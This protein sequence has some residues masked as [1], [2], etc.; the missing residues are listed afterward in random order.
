MVSVV[1]G[2]HDNLRN[3][4][5]VLVRVHVNHMEQHGS[6]SDAAISVKF[7]KK[8]IVKHESFVFQRD[9][10]VSSHMGVGRV[11]FVDGEYLWIELET[12]DKRRIT[13]LKSDCQRL[14]RK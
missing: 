6:S 7:H 12:D 8:D 3:G 10:R 5:V 4:D 9:D 11:I 13:V 2:V 1:K 14:P